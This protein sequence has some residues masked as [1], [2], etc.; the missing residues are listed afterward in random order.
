MNPTRSMTSY[1][2][3]CEK[4]AKEIDDFIGENPDISPRKLRDLEK[5]HADL[6]NQFE[7]METAWESM[8]DN[9]DDT[10]IQTAL[11]K[12]FS[13]VSDYVRKKLGISWKTILGQSSS[14]NAGAISGERQDRRH[15]QA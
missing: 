7:R 12:M 2:N 1:K 10:P 15:H 9:I 11:E 13:D 8:M 4:K 5:L 3:F 6:E 14:T